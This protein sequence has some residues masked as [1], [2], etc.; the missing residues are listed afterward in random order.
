MGR[1]LTAEQ[2]DWLRQAY[3]VSRLADLVARWNRRWGR[4]DRA[5]ALKDTLYRHHIL[6]GRPTGLAPGEA[7]PGQMS[8]IYTDEELA[9]LRT[10]RPVL[11]KGPLAAAFAARFGRVVSP[12]SLSQ[13]CIRYGIRGGGSGCFL[14][15]NRP[16]NAGRTGLPQPERMIRSQFKP[17]NRPH[18]WLPIGAYRTDTYGRWKLKVTDRSDDPTRLARRDWAFVTRLTYRDHLGPIPAG[19]CILLLDGDEDHCLDPDNLAAVSRPVLAIL[20]QTG[21]GQ[22]P[23]DRALRRAAIA[24]ATLAHAAHAAARRVG[25][26]AKARR[27]LIGGGAPFVALTPAAAARSQASQYAPRTGEAAR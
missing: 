20:N 23:P 22:L 24:A 8:R 13:T 15:G 14:R 17:G 11:A 2:L 10:Q 4:A 9:W 3:A 5:A 18:T 16:W 25:L 27:Q 6:S 21:Y 1:R 7:Q 12:D 26:S 19:H